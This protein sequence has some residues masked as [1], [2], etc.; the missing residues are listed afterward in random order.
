MNLLIKVG[1]ALDECWMN[2]TMPKQS[3]IK[4][5][6]TMK[7]KTMKEILETLFSI[8]GS[9]KS[10]S[11]LLDVILDLNQRV[12]KLLFGFFVSCFPVKLPLRKVPQKSDN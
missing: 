3:G 11:L 12:S 5:A 1:L 10:P 4:R 6:E 2:Q 8:K 9:K 7:D